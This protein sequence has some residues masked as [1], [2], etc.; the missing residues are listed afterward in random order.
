MVNATTHQRLDFDDTAVVP[1]ITERSNS[2][3]YT[4]SRNTFN[5]T[6]KTHTRNV[7]IIKRINMPMSCI[8][9]NHTLEI[10]NGPLLDSINNIQ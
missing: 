4:I 7:N 9:N 5:N 2:V 6:N 1:F 3:S 8:L 10:Q